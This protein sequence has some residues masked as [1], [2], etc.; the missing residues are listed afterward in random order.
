MTDSHAERAFAAAY[1]L[2]ALD[3]PEREAFERHLASCS[4]CAA[5]V[6]SLSPVV[7]AL[8]QAVP[9]RTPPADLR[10][11][12]LTAAASTG[13]TGP[14]RVV[15]RERPSWR[16]L[17]V[18]AL[19]LLS[20][21]LGIYAARLHSRLVA[22]EARLDDTARRVAVA[23]RAA[24]ESRGV[25]ERVRNAMAV[26]AA[27]TLLRVELGG[28]PVAPSASGRA[29]WSRGRGLVFTAANLPPLRADR[30]YQV[31][32][33]AGG[34]PISAGLM[35]PDAS[36]S[37]ELVF[38]TPPEVTGLVAVAVTEEPRGGVPAPT[39]EK[40]LVGTPAAGL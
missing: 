28:Q 30:V 38:Q 1:V 23:E 40:Y 14:G 16:W 26:L 18:A 19:A 27:P 20:I 12:V 31:W 15:I 2:S 11:R 3:P 7:P 35:Q 9:Q 8:A 13:R 39:G 22:V 10:M 37:G 29:F 32:V 33:L 5:E 21:G 25:A 24:A 34:A 36:G 4:E 6:R 17:Q